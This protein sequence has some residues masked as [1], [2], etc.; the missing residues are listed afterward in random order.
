[1][2]FLFQ[3]LPLRKN[4]NSLRLSKTLKSPMADIHA[5]KPFQSDKLLIATEQVIKIWDT[6]LKKYTK[7]FQDDLDYI[8]TLCVIDIRSFAV[9]MNNGSIQIWDFLLG[10]CT[11]VIK[12][13]SEWVG[14]AN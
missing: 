13:H 7:T 6:N 11:H 1:M 2:R 14:S 12:A 10:K 3:C 8:Y 9:G 4:T 5:I